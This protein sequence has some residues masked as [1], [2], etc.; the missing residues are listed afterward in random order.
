MDNQKL[1]IHLI[2]E[3]IRNQVLIF[4]LENLGFDCSIYTLNISENIL[5]LVGFNNK[6]DGLYQRYFEMIENAIKETSYLNMDEMMIKWS[7]VIY[8]RLYD[9]KQMEEFYEYPF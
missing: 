7:K 2:G 8:F 6:T 3:Q 5:T 1:A 4:S 9:L